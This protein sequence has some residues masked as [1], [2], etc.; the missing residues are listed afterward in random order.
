MEAVDKKQTPPIFTNGVDNDLS[1]DVC[2]QF[3]KIQ[4]CFAE[5]FDKAFPDKLAPKAVVI[6]PSLTMDQ[7]ILSKIQGITHYE[8]RL[9]CFLLLLR[10]PRT[11]VVL[12][13]CR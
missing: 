13:A 11:H 4:G 5:Q 12:P 10:M 7:E 1:D 9:L 6:I 2:A 3:K 8:E